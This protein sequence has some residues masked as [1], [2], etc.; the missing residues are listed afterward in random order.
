MLGLAPSVGDAFCY[1]T[2]T[3]PVNKTKKPKVLVQSAVCQHFEPDPTLIVVFNCETNKLQ[4]VND[5]DEEIR[6][7]FKPDDTTIDAAS[8][9]DDSVHSEENSL[10]SVDELLNDDSID[11]SSI[12]TSIE[13][14]SDAEPPIILPSS[15]LFIT[16]EE[17]SPTKDLPKVT[18]DT[19]EDSIASNLSSRQ[20]KS[21][22]VLGSNFVPEDVEDHFNINKQDDLA[23]IEGIA[24]HEWKEGILLLKL[25]YKCCDTKF[26]PCN[27]AKQDHPL[28]VADYFLSNH[29]DR[30]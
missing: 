13:G 27:I 7:E 6:P 5:K 19:D 3:E 8:L 24:D 1:R 28:A 25:A 14:A 16:P 4:F 30:A 21:A 20:E 23:K 10:S 29:A 26:H 11:D 15:E 22:L 2:L 17:I 12:D 18:Q 9:T